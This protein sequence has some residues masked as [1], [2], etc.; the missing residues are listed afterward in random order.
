M[1]HDFEYIS[2]NDDDR[3]AILE[4]KAAELEQRLLAAVSPGRRSRWPN[5]ATPDEGYPAIPAYPP[6]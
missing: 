4:N 5:V 2:Y 6:D 1:T 3:I